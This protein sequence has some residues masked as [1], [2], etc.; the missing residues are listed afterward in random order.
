VGAVGVTLDSRPA[1]PSRWSGVPRERSADATKARLLAAAEAEFAAKGFDGARL[2]S[3]ARAAGVQQALIHHYFADKEGLYGEVLARGLS[4]VT[5]ESW[6]ILARPPGKGAAGS[7]GSESVRGLVE[8][9]VDVLL[10]FY[11][12]HSALL[13]IVRHDLELPP[14]ARAATTLGDLLRKSSRPVFDA[15]AR[16]IEELK[17]RGEV[18]GDVDAR[19]LCVSTMAMACFPLQESRM[20]SALWPIDWHDPAV[21][22]TRKRE[23]VETVLSRALAPRSASP[24]LRGRGFGGVPQETEQTRAS[25]DDARGRKRPPAPGRGRSRRTPRRP[26]PRPG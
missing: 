10:R 20:L 23:I 1:P 14:E 24:S 2:G 9:F 4:A 22:A 3:I 12:T 16:R 15:V 7:S 8:A 21:L 26:A 6:D 25:A 5:E 19:H 17:E 13:A 11:A 18:R